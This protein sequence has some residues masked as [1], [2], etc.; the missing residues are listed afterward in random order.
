LDKKKLLNTLAGQKHLIFLND[1]DLDASAMFRTWA[2]TG[3]PIPQDG[4]RITQFIL[5]IMLSGEVAKAKTQ[6][7]VQLTTTKSEIERLERKLWA[8]FN[9]HQRTLINLYCLGEKFGNNNLCNR[10]I[11]HFKR[12]S[13]I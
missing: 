12:M 5:L 9:D 8:D 3:L 10:T 4:H 11:G 6:F 7:T 13:Q 2:Y 1:D